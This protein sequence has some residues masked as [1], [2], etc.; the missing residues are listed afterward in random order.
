MKKFR[1]HKAGFIVLYVLAILCIGDAVF[2]L[3][4]PALG[5]DNGYMANFSWFSYLIAVLALIYVRVY[6]VTR[7]EIDEKAMRVVYPVYIKPQPGAKRAM[8]LFRQ[9][10]TDL[11]LVN[12]RFQL[13]DMEKFGYIEDLGYAQLDKSGAGPNNKLFPVHEIALV[14]KEGKRY[15][16]NAAFYSPKQ[17][18]G[19]LEKI[20][21]STGLVAEGK[22]ADLAPQL[23]KA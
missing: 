19:M 22:L 11:K 4:S 16:M 9:G 8:F 23:K 13:A 3:I 21:A 7:V 15:H 18:A 10:E 20:H 14:M 1:P 2:S 6:A 12:K 17:L 5:I